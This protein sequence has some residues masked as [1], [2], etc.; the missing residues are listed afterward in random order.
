MARI[1]KNPEERRG[2]LIACARALFFSK[3]YDCTTVSEIIEAAGVSKG[4]FYYYFASKQAVLEAM[5]QEMV[6]QALLVMQDIVNDESL[7]ALEKWNRAFNGLGAWKME[8]RADLV[9]YATLLYSDDNVRLLHKI[10]AESN[11]SVPAQL[12][13]IIEQG[14]K[15]GV[16]HTDS[17]LEA[18]EICYAILQAH[19][20]TLI[21][22]LLHPEWF[23][24]PAELVGRKLAAMQTAIERVL[25]APPGS[26]QLM[27]GHSVQT[28]FGAS[29]AD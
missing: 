5:V 24:S 14:I 8:H 7:S 13:L 16:M 27:N 28:W 11:R 2:E 26:I 23:D 25:G 17:A 10:Q 19:S 21:R 9:A 29:P 20:D 6:E 12:A 18:A 3:G 15:E 22:I 4:T 1:V